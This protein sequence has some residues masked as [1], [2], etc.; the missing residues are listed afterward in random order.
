MKLLTFLATSSLI[1]VSAAYAASASSST[2]FM[3]LAQVEQGTSETKPEGKPYHSSKSLTP[4][5]KQK[6]RNF[7]EQ[8]RE[9]LQEMS[10]EQRQ[11]HKER[12]MERREKIKNMTPEQREKWKEH[13]KTR[14][15]NRGAGAHQ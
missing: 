8:R 12:R 4:E 6:I 11:A 13:R 7:R 14:R 1:A 5:Q 2:P 9:K 15:E 3:Q 10:P